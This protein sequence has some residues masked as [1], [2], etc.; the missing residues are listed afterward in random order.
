MGMKWNNVSDLPFHFRSIWMSLGIHI[1]DLGGSKMGSKLS[2]NGLFGSF[3]YY[4]VKD[5]FC[6]A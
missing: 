5:K 2:K 6:K 4:A 1:G 3:L